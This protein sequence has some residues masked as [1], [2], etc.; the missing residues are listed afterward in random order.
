MIVRSC[1]RLIVAIPRGD[2]SFAEDPTLRAMEARILFE[3]EA[4][5]HVLACEVVNGHGDDCDVLRMG[6]FSAVLRG[7]EPCEHVLLSDGLHN[8]RLEVR[9][10]SLLAGPAR[11]RFLL[12]GLNRID[13][14]LL[15]LRRLVAFHRLGRMP[16]QLFPREPRIDRA[17]LVLRAWDARAAG[18]SR[19]EIAALLLGAQGKE[20]WNGASDYLHSRVKRML[21]TA[22]SMARGG[23]RAL[24]RPDKG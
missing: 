5:P 6:C 14:P 13:P 4:D 2:C 11:L 10:G 22:S 23:W 9:H 24:L 8:L 16:R 3:R 20:D 18:A 15:T 1:Y 7:A 17:I 12:D 19:R 21:R